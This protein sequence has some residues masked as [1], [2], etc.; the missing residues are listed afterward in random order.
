MTTRAL[1]PERGGTL[2]QESAAV[3]RGIRAWFARPWFAAEPEPSVDERVARSLRLAQQALD[4]ADKLKFNSRAD[5]REILE[6]IEAL[7]GTEEGAE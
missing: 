3:G 4:A 1:V 7:L 2:G 6:Q 5:N